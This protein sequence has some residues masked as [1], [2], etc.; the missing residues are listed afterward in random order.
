MKLFLERKEMFS[1]LFNIIKNRSCKN[2]VFCIT[3]PTGMGKSVFAS[4]LFQKVLTDMDHNFFNINLR[5]TAYSRKWDDIITSIAKGI[6]GQLPS[7]TKTT[8]IESELFDGEKVFLFIDDLDDDI[9]EL[10]NF[11][12]KWLKNMNSSTL[13]ITIKS[14]PI[15]NKNVKEYMIFE[16]PGITREETVRELLGEQLYKQLNEFG[17]ETSKIVR[18]L[19]NIPQ[20]L[21]YLRWRSP[22]KNKGEINVSIKD[23]QKIEPEENFVDRVLKKTEIPII[24]FLA[25]AR[26]RVLEIDESLLAFLWDNLGGGN[27][28]YYQNSLDFLLREELISYK[29]IGNTRMI[30]LSAGVHIQLE[31]LLIQ[32]IGKDHVGII[33]YFISEYYRNL[34]TESLAK[35]LE[36]KWLENYIYHAL[37]AGNFNSV[38]SY[39]FASSIL[40]DAQNLGRSIELKQ[41]L[42]QYDNYWSKLL[43][44]RNLD[45]E[46][47]REFLTNRS[48]YEKAK[49][50]FSEMIESYNNCKKG[51]LLNKS[52]EK[53]KENSDELFNIE[54]AR[55]IINYISFLDKGATIKIELSSVLKD[56]SEHTACIKI[57]NKANELIK[58]ATTLEQEIDKSNIDFEEKI[59]RMNYRHNLNIRIWYISGISNSSL[60]KSIDCLNSY[61]NIIK[62]VVF[63]KRQFSSNDLL[64]LGYLAHELKF[65]DIVLSEKL[66]EIAY[67][68]SLNLVNDCTLIKNMCSLAQTLFFMGKFDESEKL[69][70]DAL[71]KC[72]VFSNNNDQ[73][74]RERGRI[75][76]HVALP[77]ISSGDFKTAEYH[78]EKGRELN[79]KFGDR[80]RVATAIA[81]KAIL[82][83][84]RGEKNDARK[85]ILE[86]IK[87]HKK[88]SDY[89]NIVNEVFSYLWMINK[90]FSSDMCIDENRKTFLHEIANYQNKNIK[91]KKG[92]KYFNHIETINDDEALELINSCIADIDNNSD[93]HLFVKFWKKY[94]KTNLLEKPEHEN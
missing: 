58:E 60:G 92:D 47:E 22:F 28:E 35:G 23:L 9:K 77:N 30:K 20:N 63:Q 4:E 64:S 70:K 31:K 54:E 40:S 80:R 65:H 55:D 81:F 15:I 10:E 90:S 79:K 46:K 86:S 3:G 48:Q 16:I 5:I 36:L 51:S 62:D 59:K 83:N 94:F 61:F 69:Y 6:M 52:W 49:N 24:H 73:D 89:R 19:S 7:K 66:G 56:L 75:Q 38:Y 1:K 93:L 84:K 53:F 67:Q 78:L 74:E 27:T 82:K 12:T 21:K 71:E 39:V 44:Q 76:I 43:N 85:T 11:L 29:I 8:E 25:L 2:R 45:L 14:A 91:A 57:L 34:F 37:N 72:D 87:Q 33:D 17:M 88:I 26:I 68:K 42:I 32:R 41:I 13:L 18:N 50:K